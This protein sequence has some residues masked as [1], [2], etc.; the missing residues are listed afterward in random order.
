MASR[1]TRL[2]R[3]KRFGEIQHQQPRRPHR[4]ETET[5]PPRIVFTSNISS[6]HQT[7]ATIELDVYDKGYW[8]NA[9]VTPRL[10]LEECRLE[11]FVHF[12]TILKV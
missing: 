2:E 6:K 5:S 11:K 9:T 8:W 7:P 1:Q 10:T 12:M 4:R 3:R